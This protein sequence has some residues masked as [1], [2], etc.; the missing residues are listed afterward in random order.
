ML[1]TF[2]NFSTKGRGAVAAWETFTGVEWQIFVAHY[3]LDLPSWLQHR[4]VRKA[5]KHV[6]SS[7][8]FSE[9]LFRYTDDFTADGSMAISC[10]CWTVESIRASLQ[11]LWCWFCKV[12]KCLHGGIL[13]KFVTSLNATIFIIQH[14]F[15]ID[16]MRLHR[17]V[18]CLYNIPKI[19]TKDK[20]A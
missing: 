16:L 14:K 6:R 15:T 11:F 7:L 12:S 20:T 3:S 4:Q 1:R 13:F 8:L 2:T 19:T 9:T 5:L 18:W 17:I 10:F